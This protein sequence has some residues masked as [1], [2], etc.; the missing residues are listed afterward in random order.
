MKKI[1]II[2]MALL[3]GITVYGQQPQTGEQPR[4]EVKWVNPEIAEM[5]GLSHHILQSKNLGH[6]VGYVVWTPPGYGKK[7]T[8]KFPVIYF[9]H[10]AGG[11]EAKDASGFSDWVKKAIDEGIISPVICVFPNGGMSGYREEV[12]K[13]IIEEL[14]PLVDKN[15]KTVAKPKGRL[16][17][18]FSMGGAGSVYLAIQHPH[19]FGAAGSMGGGIRNNNDELTQAISSA[20]PVWKKNKFRF[21]MVNGDNDRPDAFTDFS[22]LL[23]KEGI[24]NK[25]IILPDTKHNL[26]LYYE[27]SVMQLISFIGENLKK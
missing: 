8:K 13:M 17:A 16:L 23:N 22:V 4:R 6:E 27:R 24:S 11:N 9:L 18:G 14:I 3:L 15:Y 21:F 20:I 12:E 1:T 5:P 19:V 26:G 10:G 2:S 7:T 25:V